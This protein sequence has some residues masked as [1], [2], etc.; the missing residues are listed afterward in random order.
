[1]EAAKE[2]KVGGGGWMEGRTKYILQYA[3]DPSWY[4]LFQ[5]APVCMC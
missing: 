2:E 5:L 4:V 1:M 3:L